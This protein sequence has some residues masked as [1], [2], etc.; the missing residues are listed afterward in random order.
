MIAGDLTPAL[1]FFSPSVT[2][3]NPAG[4]LISR[5]DLAQSIK[6]GTLKYTSITDSEEKLAQFHEVAVLTLISDAAGSMH[7]H[8]ISGKTRYTGVWALQGG[9]WKLVAVQ[10][11]PVMDQPQ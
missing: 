10:I 2:I 3:T 1:A 5:A 6:T 8:D 4:Q 7:G 9:Q 11:T